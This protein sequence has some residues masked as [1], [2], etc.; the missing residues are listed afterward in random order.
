MRE[1][2]SFSD[3]HQLT[4]LS[5][6]T[7][8]KDLPL[9]LAGKAVTAEE[10]HAYPAFVVNF[11]PSPESGDGS[12]NTYR[13]AWMHLHPADEETAAVSQGKES[14]VSWDDLVKLTEEGTEVKM[15]VELVVP[16]FPDGPH[17]PWPVRGYVGSVSVEP[18]EIPCLKS[19]TNKAVTGTKN[20]TNEDLIKLLN[21]W[22]L[23]EPC[24]DAL[25]GSSIVKGYD[26]IFRGTSADDPEGPE[27]TWSATALVPEAQ[28]H[29]CVSLWLTD[30]ENCDRPPTYF[31][32]IG[33]PRTE[34]GFYTILGSKND[35]SDTSTAE[36]Q[37]EHDDGTVTQRNCR[38][39]GMGVRLI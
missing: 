29:S 30:A 19:S 31:T 9:T 20:P 16:R 15:E 38:R 5:Q 7:L 33:V 21:D 1:Y 26:V 6:G 28:G 3:I 11:Q 12:K 17:S 36:A 23:P 34:S 39:W 8:Q 35:A 37:P 14:G 25:T 18:R 24:E 22:D 27:E 13:P 4:Q 10:I 32:A 2:S